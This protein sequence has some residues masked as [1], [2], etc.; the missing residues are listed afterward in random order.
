M[1]PIKLLRIY[2]R[3]QRLVDLLTRASRDWETRTHQGDRMSK[4]LF[5]SKTFW[6]NILTAVAELSNVLPLPA[7]TTTLVA[8]A[9]NVGL[10]FVSS[11]PIH[12]VPPTK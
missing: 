6:F 10:R 12:V 7:G 1:N 8:A 4:S 3:A 5:A 2:T 11:Q 9:V